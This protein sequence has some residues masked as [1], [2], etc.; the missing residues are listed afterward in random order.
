MVI[1]SIFYTF[2]PED[3]DKAATILKE[4]R[5]LSRQEPGVITF[6]VGRSR[7]K[8]HVFA[9]W[10]EYRDDDAV[11]AHRESEHFKRL[12]L[13]GVR[14]LAQQRLG[15]VVVHSTE[16]LIRVPVGAV[17]GLLD[18]DGLAAGEGSLPWLQR[19][20]ALAFPSR[21][22][23][24]RDADPCDHIGRD[25]GGRIVPGAGGDLAERRKVSRTRR[26]DSVLGWHRYQIP[27]VAV[28]VYYAGQEYIKGYGITNVDSPW[29]SAVALQGE[30]ANHRKVRRSRAGV[31]SVA[32]KARRERVRCGSRRRT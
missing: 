8:P 30:A 32:E 19:M 25:I 14:V 4:L 15:E 11:T 17:S 29:S 28:G 13:N 12:G 21:A 5:D 1:Q 16:R 9:L 24:L 27:G 7:E 26:K 10:E 22:D 23:V 18:G 3:A 31:V 2:A 20:S 6:E